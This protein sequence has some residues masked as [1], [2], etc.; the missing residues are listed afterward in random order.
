MSPHPARGHAGEPR[1]LHEGARASH[2][3]G[4]RTK[5]Y[6]EILERGLRADFAEAITENFVDR[7]GRPR[8]VLERVRRDMP[9]ALHGVSLSL[10]GLDPLDEAHLRGIARLVQAI[11][12]CWVSDHLCFGTFGGHYGHDLWPLPYTEEAVRN[13]ASRIREVQD[14]LGQRIAVENVSS[15]V[16]YA[17][18]A[19]T[20][21]DFVAAVLEEADCDLLLDVN[22]VYVS[23]KNHGF[24]AR[25]YV[26]A[27]PAKRIRQLHLAGHLDRGTH[28]LDNHGSAVPDAVWSLYRHL[29]ARVGPVPAIVEW[30]DDVPSLERVL[31]E[32]AR[33]RN[34]EADALGEQHSSAYSAYAEA[35]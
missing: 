9:V 4:L 20:E 19:I 25:T 7:G 2:G 35:R 26:D 15:Y 29:V 17:A 31:A 11:E 13:T 22:N 21:W 28:L 1:A 3:I 34:E 6:P 33:A 14:R 12:P 16:E 18:S 30:D 23:A 8:A 10:G 32:S 27:I 5:H 24:D